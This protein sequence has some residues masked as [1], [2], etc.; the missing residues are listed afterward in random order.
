[1]KFQVDKK[2]PIIYLLAAGLEA[3]YVGTWGLLTIGAFICAADFLKQ[4]NEFHIA[5]AKSFVILL[6]LLSITGLI[7]KH[8]AIGIRYILILILCVPY[9][10]KIYFDR[11]VVYKAKRNF[12]VEYLYALLG[13]SVLLYLV[14]YSIA[15]FGFI[16]PWVMNGDHRNHVN[17]TR[18]V[19]RENGFSLPPSYPALADFF[20][21]IIG[22][23]GS[24]GQYF[25][26]RIAT[27][28]I[29]S[30]ALSTVLLTYLQSF[31]IGAFLAGQ[32]QL[33]KTLKYLSVAAVSFFPISQ[34]WLN[35]SLLSG[36]TAMHL[37]AV[38]SFS[39]VHI[40]MHCNAQAKTV[41]S[42]AYSAAAIFLI[43]LV[44]PI[45]AFIPICIFFG[46]RLPV[47]N[48]RV[49]VTHLIQF[50]LFIAALKIVLQFNKIEF[51]I[52]KHLNEPGGISATNSAAAAVCL[53][54][55]S[56]IYFISTGRTKA[57]ASICVVTSLV[58][59]V[60][61]AEFKRLLTFNYYPQK[62]R[63]IITYLLI[64]YLICAVL[65]H[66]NSIGN[67]VLCWSLF[68]AAIMGGVIYTNR[69]SVQ[70]YPKYSIAASIATG[71]KTLSPEEARVVARTIDIEPRSLYWM[72]SENHIAA[73]LMI[74]WGT[75]GT[76]EEGDA[77]LWVYSG[78]FTSLNE[79]CDLAIRNAPMTI[80]TK[81]NIVARDVRKYCGEDQIKIRSLRSIGL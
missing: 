19:I 1:M 3:I 9:G 6:L 47:N 74:L 42:L 37:V 66:A 68:V 33:K 17:I 70:I 28:D 49:A 79:I 71:W 59:L 38:I 65:D 22:G 26:N 2:I 48:R 23:W 46:I 13:A 53:F 12:R 75:M 50:V 61:D 39:Y 69:E 8:S 11:C 81:T 15:R 7:S 57:L 78:D 5:V 73:Q 32:S 20:T 58:Y 24:K 80:W 21:G 64:V 76:A 36:F 63:W 41:E 31:L 14:T 30:L 45:A 16:F 60:I 25:Q 77:F 27:K 52:V 54:I 10:S 56:A 29:F 34:L 4:K 44:F 67:K 62:L 35:N 51:E 40:A 55:A 18:V 43:L 72:V